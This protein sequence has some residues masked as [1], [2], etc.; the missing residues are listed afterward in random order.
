MELPPVVSVQSYSLRL[1]EVV[2]KLQNPFTA[3][4]EIIILSSQLYTYKI[5]DQLQMY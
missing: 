2:L 1:F 4:D 5:Y 3:W